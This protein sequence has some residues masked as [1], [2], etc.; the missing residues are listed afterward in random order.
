MSHYGTATIDDDPHKAEW[1]AESLR[2]YK[3]LTGD[4]TK[5]AA[6]KERLL[7]ALDYEN[8]RRVQDADNPHYYA[9]DLLRQ[10]LRYIEAIAEGGE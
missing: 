4:C 8:C 6:V 1:E 9:S 10:T 2:V 5:C 7:K 3:M